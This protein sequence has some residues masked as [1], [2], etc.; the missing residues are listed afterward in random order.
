MPRDESF[1]MPRNENITERYPEISKVFPSRRPSFFVCKRTRFALKMSPAEEKFEC[2][3][4]LEKYKEN[5]SGGQVDENQVLV[6]LTLLPKQLAGKVVLESGTG[7][8]LNGN[9]VPSNPNQKT[10]FNASES[11]SGIQDQEQR[12]GEIYQILPWKFIQR[13][14]VSGSFFLKNNI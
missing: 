14:L 2:I 6:A 3:E 9:Q 13:L 4:I 11:L 1:N 12:L 8:P 10:P 5:P 7:E